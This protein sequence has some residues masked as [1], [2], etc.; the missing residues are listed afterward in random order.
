MSALGRLFQRLSRSDEEILRD[1][2]RQWAESVPG[3]IRINECPRRR[4]VR[5]CGVVRRLT[6]RPQAG[7]HSLEAV[8]Y[9]G[10]GELTAVWTGRDHIPGLTIG[11]QLILEGVI[12]VERGSLR[13]VNPA[14]E[15]A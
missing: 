2:I 4:P 3:T 5:V 1:E 15:F 12:S 10:T 8:I 14:F 9:D 11:T 13:M 7:S 6:L